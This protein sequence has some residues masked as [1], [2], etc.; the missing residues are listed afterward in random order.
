[1]PA[2]PITSKE[3]RCYRNRG[4][5]YGVRWVPQTAGRLHPHMR[6]PTVRGLVVCAVP[7]VTPADPRTMTMPRA[8]V[9][10]M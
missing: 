2:L 8:L 3:S 9:H 1:M 7:R 6:S 10:T 5:I 4:D